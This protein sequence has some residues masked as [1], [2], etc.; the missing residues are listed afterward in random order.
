MVK[1]LLGLNCWA[2][3][4]AKCCWLDLCRSR[5]HFQSFCD[6]LTFF[7]DRSRTSVV[8]LNVYP[9][10][11]SF[12]CIRKLRRVSP[13]RK[14]AICG[15]SCESLF[16]P[17]AKIKGTT[18]PP[19]PPPPTPQPKPADVS[20]ASVLPFAAEL[21]IIAPSCLSLLIN[22]KLRRCS[23][24]ADNLLTEKLRKTETQTATLEH[25]LQ[26]KRWA[27]Q[28]KIL[29]LHEHWPWWE[30]AQQWGKNFYN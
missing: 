21:Q 5:S 24:Q 15:W 19:P 7:M 4:W 1:L 11:L 2:L 12:T 20:S 30:T 22:S 23:G 3:P 26:Q 13:E 9:K 27:A 18:P 16:S 28:R 25:V 8:G 29:W 14:S 6:L 10:Y 17:S